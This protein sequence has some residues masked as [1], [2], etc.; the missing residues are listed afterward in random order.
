MKK[1]ID[2]YIKNW[3]TKLSKKSFTKKDQE[4]LLIKIDFFNKER[5]IHLLITLFYALFTVLFVC[6]IKESLMY[7]IF[8]LMMMAFLIPYI[9]YYFYIEARVQYLYQI[10][11]KIKNSV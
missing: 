3:E 1:Q 9:V 4:D 5:L 11:D 6:H 8:A 7:F 10:Y 2:N